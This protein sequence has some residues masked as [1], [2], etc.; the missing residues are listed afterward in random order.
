VR[1]LVKKFGKRM[2]EDVIREE[3]ESLNIQVQM[4]IQVRYGR[5]DQ[6]PAKDSPPTPNFI[7]SV[8]RVSELAKVRSS[9]KL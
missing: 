7:V 4:V 5:R 8:A 9:T 1:L 2:P 6:E 3:L